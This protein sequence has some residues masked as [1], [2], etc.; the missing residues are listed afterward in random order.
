MKHK[1]GLPTATRAPTVSLPGENLMLNSTD[2]ANLYCNPANGIASASQRVGR[3]PHP[4]RRSTETPRWPR[5]AYPLRRHNDRAVEPPGNNG[6]REGHSLPDWLGAG[7]SRVI[8][9]RTRPDRYVGVVR[10]EDAI[11]RAAKKPAVQAVPQDT[12]PMPPQTTPTGIGFGHPEFHFVQAIMEMQKSLGEIKA[13]ID[14]LQKTTDS[15]K[16]KVD[17]LVKWKQMIIGGAVVFGAVCSGLGFFASK[18][19]NYIS[20][21]APSEQVQVHKVTP[22]PVEDVEPTPAPA[23]KRKASAAHTN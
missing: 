9:L 13:S 11:M 14:A 15:T 4:E 2:Y 10:D 7:D 5:L 6:A 21:K 3:K 17:D 1:N 23:P 18:F 8:V 20:F 22:A 19:S 12:S 16:S